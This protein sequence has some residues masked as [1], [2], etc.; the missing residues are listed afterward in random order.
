MYRSL[1]GVV[2]GEDV[3]GHRGAGESARIGGWVGFAGLLACAVLWA[4]APSAVADRAPQPNPSELWK[5]FPLEQRPSTVARSPVAPPSQPRPA[6]GGTL[7]SPRQSSSGVSPALIAVIGAAAVLLVLATVVGLRTRRNRVTPALALPP[8]AP[9]A[10]APSRASPVAAT[11]PARTVDPKPLV[12]PARAAEPAA[13]TPRPAAPSPNGRAAA[14]RRMPTCQVRWSSD[15]WFYAVTV[16]SDGAE[17]M[18][19]SS[20]PV[21]WREPGPPEETPG[22]KWAVQQLARDLLERD[23]RPLRQK[24]IDFDER[25]WYARRFRRPTEEELAAAREEAGDEGRQV[26]GQ[27][28]GTT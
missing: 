15:G 23:W 8:P 20:P 2:R 10:L 14:A 17:H 18:I 4:A 16:D 13:V 3:L 26:A 24:G 7:S 22:T 6:Q 5:A 21:D 25:R 1:S 11:V 19:A 12:S 9:P 28:G 27:Q